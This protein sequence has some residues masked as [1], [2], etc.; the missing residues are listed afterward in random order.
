MPQFNSQK[1]WNKTHCQYPGLQ[2][3]GYV[4]LGQPFNFWM[5][6]LRE[7][8]FF[9]EIKN[10]NLPKTA[11]ILDLGSGT[12][13]Y[14]MLWQKLAFENIT[15][16]DFSPISLK[17]LQKLAGIK[18]KQIDLTDRKL[19]SIKY[20][21]LTCFDVL[22]HIV[23]DSAYRQ[24]FKNIAG[25]LKK[26]GMFIFSE[27][28][29]PNKILRARHQVCRPGS[30]IFKLL[31]ENHLKIIKIQPV[32]FLMNNPISSSN[33][34]LRAYWFCLLAILSRLPFLGYFLGPI[35]YPLDL[36][37]G[38]VLKRGP[39]IEIIVCRKLPPVRKAGDGFTRADL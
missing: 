20:D 16:S 31:K 28:L 1:Y 37:L 34:A 12:G 8:I 17:K 36:Y 2:A 35:L 7:R 30:L 9:R 23:D 3:V 29:L 24:A 15:A 32:F 26:D 39:S 10:L 6:K 21:C 25:R 11:A 38:R 5:Y 18:V 14:P 22:Y 19:D 4:D 27:N 13:F 33:L